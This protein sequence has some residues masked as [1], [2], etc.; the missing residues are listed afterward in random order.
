[1]RT[2]RGEVLSKKR[3]ASY[4]KT[5]DLFDKRHYTIFDSDNI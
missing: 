1:M 5:L 3:R 2:I 4:D